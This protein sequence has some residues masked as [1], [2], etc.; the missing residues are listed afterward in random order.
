MK[1]T[2][3]IGS[4]AKSINRKSVETHKELLKKG[5]VYAVKGEDWIRRCCDCGFNL[6]PFIDEDELA[7]L[8]DEY[9]TLIGRRKNAD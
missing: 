3:I 4:M 5:L 8:I 7:D 2:A 6:E 9:E 1:T